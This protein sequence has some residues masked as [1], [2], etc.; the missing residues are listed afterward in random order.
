MILHMATLRE[1]PIYIAQYMSL[2]TDYIP[3]WVC[4][5]VCASRKLLHWCSLST[6]VSESDQDKQENYARGYACLGGNCTYIH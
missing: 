6:T 1:F 3:E 2:H 5:Y 4:V